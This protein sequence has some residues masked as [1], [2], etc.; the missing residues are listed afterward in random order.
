MKHNFHKSK[1]GF[2]LTEI[3]IVIVVIALLAAMAL[4]GWLRARKR[5]Q[6]GRIIADLVQLDHAVDE[7]AVDN[8]KT[9]GV[10]PSFDDLRSYVKTGSQLYQTGSD[11]FGDA[12]GPFTVDSTVQVPLGAFASLSD[13]APPDFWS[14]YPIQGP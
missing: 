14:P 6:A 10:N 5:S 2:T 4:P 11:L 9:T 1:G 8:G 12:Y 3:M 7:Y 13:V